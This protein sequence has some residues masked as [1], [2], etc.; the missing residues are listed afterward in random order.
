MPCEGAG[1]P[2]RLLDT[3]LW[4]G[5]AL[6]FAGRRLT[7]SLIY[8]I[9]Y[10]AG[11]IGKTLS[12]MHKDLNLIPVFLALMEERSV[13]RAAERLGVTQPTLSNALSRLRD[14]MND[15]LFVRESHGVQ[16]TPIA[17][18]LARIIEPALATIEDAILGQQDFDPRRAERVMTIALTGYVEYALA[19]AII[20][21][22]ATVAPRI[23]LRFR[24]YVNDLAETGVVSGNTAVVLGR[25]ID[26]PDN[27]VVQHLMDERLECIV[28]A[29]HPE[30]G[31][32]IS[33]EQFER[34]KHVNVVPPGRLRAGVFQSLEKA[35]L[36]REVVVSVTDFFAVAEVILVTD[37][38]GTLPR[39]ICRRLAH[40]ARL[41]V[42]ETPVDLQNFPVEMA[43]H[44]RYRH[45]SA[46]RW[47]RSLIADVVKDV[48]ASA[49]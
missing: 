45:D 35:G 33:R 21:R 11:D 2:F 7:A 16:P 42:L 38:C 14:M 5:S 32:R 30:I 40:D 37:Y 23:K 27:L 9:Y 49:A 17:V 8:Q 12:D 10:F 48:A 29:D 4:A 39:L 3:Q 18:E 34:L 44:V 19:P 25:M 28:R 15:Q 22:L 31:D 46:H 47:L 24:P 41:K 13:S 1:L 6:C 36:R 43:W 20:A 26:P